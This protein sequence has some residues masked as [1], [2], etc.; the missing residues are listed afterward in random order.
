[1]GVGELMLLHMSAE[2]IPPS[3]YRPDLPPALERVIP[4]AL[5][6]RREDRWPSMADFSAALSSLRGP[7]LTEHKGLQRTHATTSLMTSGRAGSQ[8][9]ADMSAKREAVTG[10]A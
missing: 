1:V 2:P 7:N 9:S 5:A 8:T 10:T 4:R 3:H 6:K